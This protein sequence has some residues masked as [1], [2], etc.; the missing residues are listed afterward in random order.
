M[1]HLHTFII[2]ASLAMYGAVC[3][4]YAATDG[5][6]TPVTAQMLDTGYGQVGSV[7]EWLQA[8]TVVVHTPGDEIFLG[9]AHPAAA[10]FERPF[11]LE[12]AR[13]CRCNPPG[14]TRPACQ[15]PM[16]PTRS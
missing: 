8:T 16:A 15:P 1:K 7:A 5:C 13:M 3:P 10:L 6:Q 2:V 11:S 9:L 14:A 12:G 4:V